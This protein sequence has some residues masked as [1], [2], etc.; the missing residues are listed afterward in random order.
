[1][2]SKTIIVGG[3]SAGMSCALKLQEE[4]QDF[5]LVTD[6][7]GGRMRYSEEEKVN[8]GAYFIMANYEN[9]K[10]LVTRETLL[11][12][13]KACFHNSSTQYFPLVSFHTL[14]RAGEYLRFRK[15]MKEFQ[16]H[17][18]PYKEKCMV[19]TQKDAMESDPYMA[20]LF[21]K[22]ASQLIKEK[23][24]EK[25][26]FDYASKFSYACTGVSM[27]KITALD[28][29]NVS[30]GMMVPIHRFK[31][32][33]KRMAAKLGKNL[34]IDAIEKIE[35]TNG[36]H[37]LTG[38]SG[39]IYEADNVVIATPAIVTKEL[40]NLKEIRESCKLY[41]FH[42]KC[43][44]KQPYAKYDMNL[45]PFESEFIFTSIQDDGTQL[46]YSREKEVDLSKLCESYE[47]I[48]RVDWDRA[49]YVTGRAYMEQQVGKSIYV[50]GDHNG[51][52]LE[53]TACSGIYA[54]NQIIK[55]DKAK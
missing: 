41:V 25:F 11:N 6:I 55:N 1:M 29:C 31:F 13:F 43:K 9:A 19:M 50:A 30:M 2:K 10:K 28:F 40:L 51:L 7:L 39:E 26:A 37:F 20:D 14:T 49:M 32:D 8:F 21:V 52:G 36:K 44:L 23:R 5:L 22:P 53:P 33:Q 35:T 48:S 24:I 47:L 54:A 12:P 15:M 4:N 45:F 46:I 17:Y 18:E 27:D 34:V 42:V 38:K 16:A 3:G